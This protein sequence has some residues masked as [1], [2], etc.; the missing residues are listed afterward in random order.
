MEK[1]NVRNVQNKAGNETAVKGLDLTL[2]NL[3]LVILDVRERHV[4]AIN[5]VSAAEIL[6][7]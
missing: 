7:R 5:N 3:L 6:I 4:Q 2:G 1:A